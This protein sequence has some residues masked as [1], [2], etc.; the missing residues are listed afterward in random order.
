MENQNKPKNPNAFPI[1]YQDG[2]FQTGMTL[3]DYFAAKAMQGVIAST[4]G[5]GL[6]VNEKHIKIVV[7]KAYMYADAMLKERE[8]ATD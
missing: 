7:K 8:K 2:E 4:Q 3:R 1:E 6:E 5:I